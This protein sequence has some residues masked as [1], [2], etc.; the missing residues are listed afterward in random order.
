MK[1]PWQDLGHG[2]EFQ[3][4]ESFRAVVA[5]AGNMTYHTA[6]LI[7]LSRKPHGINLS[8][9]M[10][11]HT[12]ESSHEATPSWHAQAACDAGLKINLQ[13]FDP[14]MIACFSHCARHLGDLDQQAR[15]M[16]FMGR[17]EQASWRMG[18]LM[19]WLKTS[20]AAN[21]PNQPPDKSRI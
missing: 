18:K 5:V 20:W 4:L 19:E 1:G 2:M 10:L 16:C 12:E 13:Y 6:M 15:V 7:M 17:L 21:V 3:K 8:D 14:A 9:V 11:F